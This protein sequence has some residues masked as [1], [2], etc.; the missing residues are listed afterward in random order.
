MARFAA[1]IRSGSS[2]AGPLHPALIL[3]SSEPGPMR[4]VADMPSWI[5]PIVARGIELSEHDS[6]VHVLTTDNQGELNG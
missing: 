2:C 4:R 1:V 3:V 5:S 6:E